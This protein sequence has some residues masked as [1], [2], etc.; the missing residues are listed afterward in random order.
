MDDMSRE[1]FLQQC[2]YGYGYHCR[3]VARNWVKDHEESRRY[4]QADYIMMIEL[5]DKED[6][7]KSK[8]RSYQ[9]TSTTKRLKKS[10]V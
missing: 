1:E 10:S 7:Q 4:T 3:D 5:T 2:F 9:N 8:F 6:R